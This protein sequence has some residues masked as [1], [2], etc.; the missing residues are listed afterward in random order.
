MKHNY[1][2]MYK[3]NIKEDDETPVIEETAPV[4]EQITEEA[5]A[6]EVEDAVEEVLED[7]KIPELVEEKEE[8]P[9]VETPVTKPSYRGTVTGGLNLNI[10]KAPGG[11]IVK[12]VSN[13]S[14]V[15][16]EDDSNPDWYKISEPVE[17]F[18]MKKFVKI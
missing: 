12:V 8:E 14:F 2:N 17:G 9:K 5:P 4:E 10:R 3:S 11:D 18:V 16:I 15:T 6:E 7:V 1:N 13:G